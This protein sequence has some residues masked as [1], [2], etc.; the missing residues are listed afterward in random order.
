[1]W[2]RRMTFFVRLSCMSHLGILSKQHHNKPA[3]YFSGGFPCNAECSTG[4]VDVN[5]KQE[6][7]DRVKGVKPQTHGIAPAVN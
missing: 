4:H 2:N 6:A 5:N 7:A 3:W 1:M